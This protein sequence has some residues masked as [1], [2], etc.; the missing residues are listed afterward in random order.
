MAPFLDMMDGQED[1]LTRSDHVLSLGMAMVK[2][3]PASDGSF[4]DVS[5]I[6]QHS[7]HMGRG[8]K[9]TCMYSGS[10]CPY[11]L[12]IKP[13]CSMVFDYRLRTHDLVQS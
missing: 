10:M 9:H 2:Y 13:W 1:I 12:L 6:R 8:R 3:P 4:L 11:G 7:P 5:V